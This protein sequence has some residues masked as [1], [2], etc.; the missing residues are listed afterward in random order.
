MR[1]LFAAFV[2][3]AVVAATPA[4]FALQ[5]DGPTGPAPQIVTARVDDQGRIEIA[6]V[7]V[8]WVAEERVRTVRDS[9]GRTREERYLV[10]RPVFEMRAA[11]SS[12]AR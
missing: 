7:V 6:E 3:L 10:S 8:R 11:P 5:A 1:P 4:V 12:N 9:E 2:V